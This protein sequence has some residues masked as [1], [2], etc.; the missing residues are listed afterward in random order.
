VT[1]SSEGVSTGP[2]DD[3]KPSKGTVGTYFSRIRKLPGGLEKSLYKTFLAKVVNIKNASTE[4]IV[5]DSNPDPKLKVESGSE[6]NSFGSTTLLL[7]G[8]KE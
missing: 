2:A 1:S 8:K 3:H 4:K 7:K 6:R 5:S